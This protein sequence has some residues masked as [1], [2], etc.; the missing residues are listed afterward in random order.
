MAGSSWK[1]RGSSCVLLSKHLPLSPRS[2]PQTPPP[3]PHLCIAHYFRISCFFCSSEV[4]SPMDFCLWSYI[5][6]STMLRVS[7][8]RSDSWGAD[9]DR[10]GEALGPPRPQTS[11]PQL[12]QPSWDHLGVLGFYLLSI[13]LRVTGY[14]AAPPLH[15]FDL[16]GRGGPP[17]D[18]WWLT[19]DP[20]D[21]APALLE[22]NSLPAT[23]CIRDFQGLNWDLG[24]DG[25]DLCPPRWLGET[26]TEIASMIRERIKYRGRHSSR[27]EGEVRTH[28]WAGP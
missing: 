16:R 9:S 23:S 5:I 18:G 14:Q 7:L 25:R 8:S 26:D 2:Q 11:Q 27:V 24:A 3:N 17:R 28:T 15:L 10:A 4:G 22:P 12:L 21:H 20:G 19:Q 1:G 6:F 13:D